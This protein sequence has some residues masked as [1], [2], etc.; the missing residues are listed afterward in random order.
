V[1]A[2]RCRAVSFGVVVSGRA[3]QRLGVTTNRQPDGTLLV[4]TV[5]AGSPADGHLQAGDVVVELNGVPVCVP[6]GR[7]SALVNERHRLL[8]HGLLDICDVCCVLYTIS[9]RCTAVFSCCLE[10]RTSFSPVVT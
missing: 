6:G 5:A 2:V 7:A 3:N 9:L 4:T 1:N 10:S 8:T